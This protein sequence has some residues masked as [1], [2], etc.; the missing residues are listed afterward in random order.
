VAALTVLGDDEEL[1]PLLDLDHDEDPD[2]E[3]PLRRHRGRHL[4]GG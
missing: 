1:R 2:D 3:V 4:A